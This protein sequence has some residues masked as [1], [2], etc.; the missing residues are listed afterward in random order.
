VCGARAGL[1]ALALTATLLVAGCGD[2]EPGATAAADPPTTSPS[3]TAGSPSA[4][5]TPASTPAPSVGTMI[6]TGDSEFGP[7]LFDERGQAIYLF[8]LEPTSTPGC[9]DDCAAAWPPVLTDGMPRAA[10]AADAALLGATQRADGSMQ[11]TYAGHPLYF[12]AHEAPGE[13]LCHDVFLNG[14]WWYVV[15]PGGGAA[16]A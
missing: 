16:P 10:G 2:G 12:Y 3:T 6:T 5:P 15:T 13:V 8:D 4:P 9:Y 14:G 11:V 7:M 1:T